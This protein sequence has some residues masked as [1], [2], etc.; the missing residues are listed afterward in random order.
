MIATNTETFFSFEGPL[1]VT[2][3]VVLGVLLAGLFGWTLYREGRLTQRWLIPV[4]WLLRVAM[5]VVVLWMLLGPTD[6][7]VREHT[8]PRT[9]AIFADSSG[10]MDVVDPPAPL[11]DLRWTLACDPSQSEHFLSL[12]D[13]A[14]QSA[15]A[16]AVQFRD[17]VELLERGV[18]AKTAARSL[19]A[20]DS[21]CSRLKQALD[22]MSESE[23]LSKHAQ[24]VADLRET[25]ETA[26]S[27]LHDVAG[28][29]QAAELLEQDE[30]ARIAAALPK[31]EAVAD[32]MDRVVTLAERDLEAANSPGTMSTP[33]TS[34]SQSRRDKVAALMALAED[35]WLKELAET[36]RI[37]RYSLSVA[38]EGLAADEWSESFQS[39]QLEN[40]SNDPPLTDL[41]AGL[42]RLSRDA[43]GQDVAAAVLLTDGRHN[44]PGSRHPRDVAAGLGRLPVHVVPI[45]SARLL[46]DVIVHHVDAPPAVAKDDLI[47]IEAIVTASRCE[48]ESITVELLKN[49]RVIDQKQVSIDSDREDHRIAFATKADE[50]GRHE[51]RI[52]TEVLDEEIDRDNNV[53]DFAVETIEESLRILL[54][55][56]LPRWEFRYLSFLFSRDERVEFEQLLFA[57]EVSGTGWLKN[58]PAFPDRVDDW[59]RYRLVILGD[60]TPSQLSRD[61]Q[62]ALVKYVT[63][64]GGTLVVIA[65]QESM[66]H[67][68]RGEPLERLIP[69]EE[70]SDVVGRRD[71]FHLRLTAEG[72]L[73]DAM[74]FGDAGLDSDQIW[75]EMSRSLPI[76]SLSEYSRPKP[77]SHTLIRAVS[78]D[79]DDP[80]ENNDGAG[81]RAFL[82]WQMVGRGRV[83]YLAAPATYQLRIRNGDRYHHQFWG[84]LIRWA[85]A[86]DLST[87]S[88]TVR[89]RTDKSA[90]RVGEQVEAIVQLR[91]LDGSPV[92]DAELT[93]TASQNG[94]VKATVALREDTSIPGRYT[95]RI[96]GLAAGTFSVSA[97][98]PAVDELLAIE[99]VDGPV[100]TP[101]TVEPTL[102]AEM[103]DTRADR[104][105]LSQIAEL[106]GGRV[107]PPT[108]LA[109]VLQNVNLAPHVTEETSRQPL[110]NSWYFL[111][112]VFLCLTA[113]WGI[114]KLVGL[115]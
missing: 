91:K 5:L 60:V 108:A 3:A 41:T 86:R 10:S 58:F 100:E 90:F 110:W 76:Y 44:K 77:T 52:R 47:S 34:V 13:R 36:V 107:I 43:A 95:G 38:A 109:E 64:R 28:R 68:F 71:G 4:F 62:N 84:Q 55:D 48:G 81:A 96:D 93:A 33:P 8:T 82:C 80:I 113:E 98:G 6:V 65:G 75:R 46:R 85:V 7:T 24:V 18:S 23:G 32:Q 2:T 79:A 88:K 115:S 87:G 106:T 21:A 27:E 69:V 63:Q 54:A 70:N 111:W 51:F 14:R 15:H 22:L 67:E 49:E 73:A 25:V 102:S 66:P 74:Q 97:T 31:L 35:T 56:N 11:D 37:R 101:V 94:K 30:T 9:I 50:F 42:E 61:S 103:T 40:E 83:V 114:R 17:G 105:L 19:Q 57:P 12:T 20:A 53:A 104:P 92:R 72:K 89:I 29:L 26:S 59:S 45:G 99:Q 16:A 39:G 112:I 78:T 1:N